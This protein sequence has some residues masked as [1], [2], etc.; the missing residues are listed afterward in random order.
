[1]S[2]PVQQAGNIDLGNNDGTLYVVVPE[3][4]LAKVSSVAIHSD[5]CLH[6]GPYCYGTFRVKQITD[7]EQ[8]LFCRD[9][10]LRLVIPLS[11]TRVGEL[12]GY[13]K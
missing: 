4:D 2:P 10:G 13:L 1:M 11:V 8:A 6:H 7:S 12:E 5:S 9:C 3:E